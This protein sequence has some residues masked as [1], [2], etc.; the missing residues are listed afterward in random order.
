GVSWQWVLL[1]ETAIT[2]AGIFSFE[3]LRGFARMKRLKP[4]SRRAL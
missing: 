1:T 4:K 3:M 2:F